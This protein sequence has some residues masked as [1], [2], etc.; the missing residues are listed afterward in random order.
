MKKKKIM[1][2]GGGGDYKVGLVR[3]SGAAEGGLLRDT[4]SISITTEV[5]RELGLGTVRPG[6]RHGP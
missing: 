5:T 4:R 2:R 1:K 3:C 6:V